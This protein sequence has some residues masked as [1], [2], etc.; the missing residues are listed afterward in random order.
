MNPLFSPSTA[1][2]DLVQRRA[3][4]ITTI[5]MGMLI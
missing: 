2:E 3:V 5:L 1:A 4:I